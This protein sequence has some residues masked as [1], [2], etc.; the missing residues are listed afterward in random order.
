M[1]DD[2]SHLAFA[3]LATNLIAG[4]IRFVNELYVKD[5]TGGTTGGL[6]LASVAVP[7]GV[8]VDNSTNN[9]SISATG[10]YVSYDDYASGSYVGTTLVN[11]IAPG[12][13]DFN[14]IPTSSW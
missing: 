5:L 14:G 10:A 3:S 11:G 1:S 8:E 9:P 6:V 4:T 13:L 2:A 7:T 12:V